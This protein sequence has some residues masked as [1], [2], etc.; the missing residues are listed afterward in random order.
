MYVPANPLLQAQEPL[1]PLP[2][3]PQVVDVVG[4]PILGTAMVPPGTAT[5]KKWFRMRA[6]FGGGDAS[7]RNVVNV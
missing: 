5:S 4:R 1:P 3:H 2:P 6:W 7:M